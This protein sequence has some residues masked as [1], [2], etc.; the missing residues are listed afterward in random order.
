[1]LK[2]VIRQMASDDGGLPLS[3]FSFNS[4]TLVL[5]KCIRLR[6][7]PH[8][9]LTRADSERKGEG[10]IRCREFESQY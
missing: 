8:I 4:Q 9:S 6:G 3:H 10:G 2:S 1:M 5:L 7:P